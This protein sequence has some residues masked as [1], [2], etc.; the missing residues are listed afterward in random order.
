MRIS[1]RLFH[2]L[3]IFL[4]L[5]TLL[6]EVFDPSSNFVRS[7]CSSHHHELTEAS[8][9]STAT[10]DTDFDYDVHH[11]VEAVYYA[12]EPTPPP[13]AR[14]RPFNQTI[15]DQ[16]RPSLRLPPRQA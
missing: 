15:D 7:R 5:A 10:P 3:L 11:C 2:F 14:H 6:T 9:Q 1:G 4:V 13:P 12:F 16:Y 8:A